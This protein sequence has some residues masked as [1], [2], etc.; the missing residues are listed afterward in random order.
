MTTLPIES[1][2]DFVQHALSI[3]THRDETVVFR[4]HSHGAYQTTPSVLRTQKLAKNEHLMLRDLVSWH[5][6]DFHADSTA[7][8]LLVRAQHYGLP[9]RLL[10]VTFNPLAALFF[11]CRKKWDANAEVVAFL[12]KQSRIKR[13]DSDTVSCLA[14]LAFLS[15]SEK[16]RIKTNL[17]DMLE[18]GRFRD[19]QA[20]RNFRKTKPMKRLLHFIRHEKPHFDNLIRPPTLRQFVVVLPKRSNRRIVAQSGAFI[21]CGC[22]STLRERV[23]PK[24]RMQRFEIPAACKK[25]ICSDLSKL[26]IDERTMFPEIERTARFLHS[27]YA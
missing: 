6:E 25:N 9:T 3:R 13:Y 4:G 8:E 1:V 18:N 2:T 12:A 24:F 27:Q 17:N 26:G 22:H 19:R 14:N 16:S 11:A 20:I 10:D 21:V 15:H 23:S 5:P 7:L